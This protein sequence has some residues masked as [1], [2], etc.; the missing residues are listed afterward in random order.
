MKA[1]STSLWSEMQHQVQAKAQE[2][3][4]WLSFL[5]PLLG[6]VLQNLV[7]PCVTSENYLLWAR[8]VS[9]TESGASP[10]SH[11]KM[12]ENFNYKGMEG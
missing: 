10:S 9:P 11:L 12:T 4:S 3:S 7:S 6:K 2:I 1:G 5:S 8:Q